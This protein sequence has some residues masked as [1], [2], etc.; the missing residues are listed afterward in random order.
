MTVYLG[1]GIN[2]LSDEEAKGW[3]AEANELLDGDVLDPMARDYRGKED[4]NVS[5]IVEGDKDDID[6]CNAVIIYA[7]RASWGTAMECHY[8]WVNGK[9]VVVVVPEGPVSPWLR[10]HSAAVVQTVVE[11]CR[12]TKAWS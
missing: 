2:G 10:Y 4:E 6:K 8:A 7:K 1:G 3:R 5:A 11:A 9:Y 12:L